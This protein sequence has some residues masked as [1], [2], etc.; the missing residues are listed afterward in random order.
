MIFFSAVSVLLSQITSSHIDLHFFFGGMWLMYVNRLIRFRI[1][2]EVTGI[3]LASLMVEV[4]RES[5]QL[6]R[7]GSV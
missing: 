7:A 3:G 6:A 1:K 5:F 4:S 2:L